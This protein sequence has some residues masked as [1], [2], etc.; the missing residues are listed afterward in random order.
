MYT[1]RVVDRS[2]TFFHPLNPFLF[3]FFSSLAR[4]KV[5]LLFLCF[6]SNTSTKSIFPVKRRCREFWIA[7]R[8]RFFFSLSCSLD[9]LG[10]L[11]LIYLSITT[12]ASRSISLATFFSENHGFLQL[13]FWR[14]FCNLWKNFVLSIA[15]KT[16]CTK[17]PK[18]K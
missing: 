15:S 2:P 8:K 13:I 12:T 1:W 18:D 5:S 7:V 9:T 10:N 6:G 4:L 17:L 16:L 11:S 3:R 14:S